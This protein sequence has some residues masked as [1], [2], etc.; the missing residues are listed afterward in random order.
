[1]RGYKTDPSGTVWKVRP[2]RVKV[3]YATGLG[4]R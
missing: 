4:P 2:Q 1:L 3:P